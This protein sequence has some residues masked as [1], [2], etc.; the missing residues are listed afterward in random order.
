MMRARIDFMKDTIQSKSFTHSIKQRNAGASE[1]NDYSFVPNAE[2]LSCLYISRYAPER[3]PTDPFAAL[4]HYLSNH[5][6]M[7][8]MWGNSKKLDPE[9]RSACNQ[10]SELDPSWRGWFYGLKLLW[11]LLNKNQKPDF[12]LCGVDE[13]SLSL[14]ISAGRRSGSPV[15]SIIEDPPFT[16]RYRSTDPLPRKLEKHLRTIILRNLLSR[17][18]GIFCFIE[19]EV[20]GEFRPQAPIYQMMNGVSSRAIKLSEVLAD[21]QSNESNPI[22]GFVGAVD[23]SQGIDTLVKIFVQARK[24]L[25]GLRLRLIGPANADY[26][27]H[28]DVELE[29]LHLRDA[30]EITG[31][32]PYERMME[33]LQDCFVGVYCN[34]PTDWYLHAQPLKICEYLGLAKPTVAWDYPG[35]RRLLD[36]GRLGIL[37]PAGD[38][39]AFSDGLVRMADR[40]KRETMENEIRISLGG[41]WASDF[42]YQSVIEQATAS[43]TGER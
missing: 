28:L 27:S 29:D 42:W 9:F 24:R 15:F 21:K 20:L 2:L 12:I 14:G 1:V 4:P 8:G 30:V 31:W 3:S 19:A 36:N 32:L 22:V 6:R 38:I 11:N 17:C 10:I 39:E 7:T 18:R 5:T 13:F 23:P 43:S 26:Q 25:P 34:P 35:V 40:S 41:R 37:I 33:K 16:A